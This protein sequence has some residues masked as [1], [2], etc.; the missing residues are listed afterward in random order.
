MAEEAEEE[1]VATS[2][3]FTSGLNEDDQAVFVDNSFQNY[4][5]QNR[6][7]EEENEDRLLKNPNLL[8]IPTQ[9]RILMVDDEPFNI[10]GMQIT[11]N[12]LNIK[13]IAK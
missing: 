5:A 1:S 8:K 13:G 9:K 2:S 6:L 7:L 11:M 10:L 12:Q 4:N 3:E